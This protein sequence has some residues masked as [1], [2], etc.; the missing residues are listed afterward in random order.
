MEIQTNSV[1]AICEILSGY[2]DKK[3]SKR[4]REFTFYILQTIL[5]CLNN[6]DFNNLKKSLFALSDLAQT[7]PIML[8]KNFSDIYTLMGKIIERKDLDEDSIRSVAF[9]VLLSIIEKYSKVISEDNQKLTL[10]INSIFKY[11]MEFDEEI[12]DD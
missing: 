2:I 3:I 4:F 5:N 10:L 11:G 6:N 12:N 1:E 7:Q 9:E 8:K